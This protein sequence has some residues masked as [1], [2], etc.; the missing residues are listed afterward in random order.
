M[1]DLLVK[2]KKSKNVED[3]ALMWVLQIAYFAWPKD[4]TFILVNDEEKQI[5]KL[6]KVEPWN[7]WQ[8]CWKIIE[9]MNPLSKY[10]WQ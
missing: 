6:K 8:S 1:I 9:T 5:L 7:V 2:K 10:I 4:S 3:Y